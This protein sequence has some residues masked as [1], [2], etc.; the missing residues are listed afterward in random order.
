MGTG[1]NWWVSNG[2]SKHFDAG[3]RGVDRNSAPS[4]EEAR[5]WAGGGDWRKEVMFLTKTIGGGS[6]RKREFVSGDNDNEM[7]ISP[8]DAL[9]HCNVPL[10]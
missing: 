9:G 7:Q 10:A 5:V 1:K 2:S 4:M 8:D 6:H 3:C